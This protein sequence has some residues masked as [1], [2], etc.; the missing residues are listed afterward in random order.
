[1][2][3]TRLFTLLMNLHSSLDGF[4]TYK[5]GDVKLMVVHL[6]SS[7]D[8]FLTLSGMSDRE[9]ASYIYILV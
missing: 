3:Q 2:V 1:M 9:P 5:L 8:G 4:L 7:L 6:H